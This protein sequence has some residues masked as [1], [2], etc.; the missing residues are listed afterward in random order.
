MTNKMTRIGG[1]DLQPKVYLAGP[2]VF[3]ENPAPLDKAKK[4]IL[5]AFGLDGYVP[6][7]NDLALSDSNASGQSIATAIARANFEM[8]GWCDSIL[9]QLTPFRGPSADVGTVGELHYMY[10]LGK[11]VFAYSNDSRD[12]A[13]RT[14]EDYYKGNVRHGHDE[15][16]DQPALYGDDGLF[17]EQY[18]QFDNLMIPFAITDSGG[19]MHVCDAPAE[20]YYTDLTA[21]RAA[22]R[23]AAVYF[24]G[25]E[26]IGRLD[27][28][29]Q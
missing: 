12:Y 29:S 16:F 1:V 28:R 13:T 7:D 6:T 21:F 20:T 5:E 4:E 9:A 18:G 19:S 3:L 11:P 27:M 10:G 17:I 26:Q 15:M 24:Y 22:A 2:D 25:E 8:M 23:A 14:A